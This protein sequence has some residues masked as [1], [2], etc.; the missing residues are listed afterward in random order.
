MAQ[1]DVFLKNNIV[2][3]DNLIWQ[4]ML[5]AAW[6]V[7]HLNSIEDKRKSMVFELITLLESQ[8]GSVD[9]AANVWTLSAQDINDEEVVGRKTPLY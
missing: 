3:K 8:N 1:A 9:N 2:Y 4:G 5:P 7:K 6:G